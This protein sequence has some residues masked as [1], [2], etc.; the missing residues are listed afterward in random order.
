M[1]KK[2]CGNVI[3]WNFT[4]LISFISAYSL[5]CYVCKGTEEACSKSKLEADKASKSVDCPTDKCMRFWSKKDDVTEVVNSCSSSALC[6][7]AEKACDDVKEGK[8]AVGCC[9]SDYCNAGSSFSFS[10]ILMTVTSALGLALL[11]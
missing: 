10:V 4:F 2:A 11:K 7:A 9:D 8:C 6:T 1:E 3:N 5:K